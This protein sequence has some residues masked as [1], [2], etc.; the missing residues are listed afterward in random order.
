[1]K[2]WNN[3]SCLA[4]LID[5]QF[6]K[7]HKSKRY[8]I[9]IMIVINN[10]STALCML[11]NSFCRTEIT[12]YGLCCHFQPVLA[13]CNCNYDSLIALVGW[14]WLSSYNSVSRGKLSFAKMLLVW[15]SKISK[16]LCHES[17]ELHTRMCILHMLFIYYCLIHTVNVLLCIDNMTLCL[18]F[19]CV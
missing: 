2:K 17:A 15:P 4:G 8:Q 9:V 3:F 19:M 6:C 11:Y 5:I 12:A 10:W 16:C 13:Y 14:Q 1:M 7:P 18:L